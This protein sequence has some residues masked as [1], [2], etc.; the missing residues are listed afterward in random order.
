MKTKILSVLCVI[1]AVLSLCAC[2]QQ[3]AAEDA[4]LRELNGYA[5]ERYDSYTIK[6]ETADRNGGKVTEL[7][8]ITVNNGLRYVE[9]R[10]EE[11]NSFTIDGDTVT[12]PE[13]YMTVRETTS[14]VNE[15]ESTAF[16]LPIFQLD[17]DS[18]KNIKIDKDSYPYVL[19]ADV[20]STA[21]LMQNSID[22]TNFKIEIEYVTGSLYSLQL[23]YKTDNG[24]NVTVTYTFG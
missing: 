24:N 6:I 7:H 2:G 12:A 13:E 19:T 21:S 22:G 14:T 5:S 10:F 1:A 23:R 9:S 4:L 15:S 18:L 20:I 17:R 3:N 11:I 16:G 8:S